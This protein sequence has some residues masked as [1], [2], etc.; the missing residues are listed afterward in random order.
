MPGNGH[1]NAQ[2]RGL[3][4]ISAFSQEL[5]AARKVIVLGST[6]E[7]QDGTRDFKRMIRLS[8]EIKWN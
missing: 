4:A 8:R 3:R 6:Y 7:T 5:M 2:R 1:E